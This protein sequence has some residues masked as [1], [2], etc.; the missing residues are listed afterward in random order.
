[1]AAPSVFDLSAGLCWTNAA[2][3][4]TKELRAFLRL[5]PLGLILLTSIDLSSPQGLHSC[6]S[7]VLFG[8]ES[9]CVMCSI[10]VFINKLG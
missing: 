6:L 5:A 10:I 7:Y 4:K 9:G 2:R 3:R 1:M 8:L